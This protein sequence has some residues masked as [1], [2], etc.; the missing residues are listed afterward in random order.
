MMLGVFDDLDSYSSEAK[1]DAVLGKVE[2]ETKGDHEVEITI[3]AFQ[4]KAKKDEK[5]RDEL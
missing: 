1:D 4:V 2:Y 5:E 3:E